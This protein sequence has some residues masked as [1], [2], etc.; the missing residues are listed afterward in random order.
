MNSKANK[1]DNMRI[2]TT[3]RKAWHEFII[4]DTYEAGIELKGSE[5]KSLRTHGCSIQESYAGQHGGE[6]FIIGMYI[7]PYEKASIDKQDP[8]RTRRL[9]LHRDE[10]D[11][12]ITKTTQRGYTL[13]PL[14]VYFR[15]GWAKVEIGV[16]R[17]RKKGDKRRKK[18]ERQQK[19]EIDR[20]LG[21]YS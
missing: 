5:V 1:N 10:I 16:A 2:V 18:L 4:E 13:I 7:P 3:N 12:I 11:R 15:Q 6:I 20:E 8:V 21:R 17:K 9:L 14:K 19:R